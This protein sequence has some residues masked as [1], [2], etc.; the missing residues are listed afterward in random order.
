[1]VL[2]IIFWWCLGVMWCWGSDLGDPGISGKLWPLSSTL[3][4]FS[5]D[6]GFKLTEL[7]LLRTLSPH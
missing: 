2:E 6:P 4:L 5:T 3:K 7:W 1:M